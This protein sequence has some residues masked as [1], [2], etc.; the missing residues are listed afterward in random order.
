MSSSDGDG[1]QP[2]GQGASVWGKPMWTMG[3][4]QAL[5]SVAQLYYRCIIHVLHGNILQHQY[6]VDTSNCKKLPSDWSSQIY[7]RGLKQEKSLK[8]PSWSMRPQF[9][10]PSKSLGSAFQRLQSKY[11]WNIPQHNN[12]E[13]IQFKY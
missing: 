7:G 13:K 1:I 9:S 12:I 3:R 4:V 6:T 2:D 5:Y 11:C 10:C 8:L